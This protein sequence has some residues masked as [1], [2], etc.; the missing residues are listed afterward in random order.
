[1]RCNAC[2][3]DVGENHKYCPLCGGGLTD[4]P[5]VLQGLTQAPYP[6]L[7]YKKPKPTPTAI[8]FFCWI[9][10]VVFI[11]SQVAFY[12][13]SH[14]ITLL[15]ASGLLCLWTAVVR[16]ISKKYLHLSNFAASNLF[17]FSFLALVSSCYSLG[18]KAGVARFAGFGAPILLLIAAAA[19]FSAAMLTRSRR[20]RFVSDFFVLLLIGIALIIF[21]RLFWDI[22]WLTFMPSCAALAALVVLLLMNPR[23]F[24]EELHA[25]FHF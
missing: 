15:T 5:P 8:F 22:D 4:E 2:N 21:K 11:G 24:A 9:P 16:P 13:G 25:R 12:A 20:Y 6:A 3:V 19:L 1:M 23:A 14:Y 18:F 10:L 17:T 7:R